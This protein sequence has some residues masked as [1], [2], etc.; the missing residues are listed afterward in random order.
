MVTVEESRQKAQRMLLPPNITPD[1]E[2]GNVQGASCASSD[3]SASLDDEDES[4]SGSEDSCRPARRGSSRRAAGKSSRKRRKRPEWTREEEETLAKVHC[5]VGNQWST[6]AARLPGRT[7]NEVKNIWHSTLR[8]K[9]LKVRSLLRAYAR[10]LR[11]RWD[12]SEARQEAYNAAVEMHSTDGDASAASRD[13]QGT[14]GA[15]TATTAV[16]AAAKPSLLPSQPEGPHSSQGG[17]STKGAPPPPM[18]HPHPSLHQ[19]QQIPTTAAAVITQRMTS[20]SWPSAPSLPA[21]TTAAAAGAATFGGVPAIAVALPST[22]AAAVAAIATDS[23]PAAAGLGSVVTPVSTAVPAA[24]AALHNATA[25]PTEPRPTPPHSSTSPGGPAPAT[26]TRHHPSSP[27]QHQASPSRCMKRS[28]QR[29]HQPHKESPLKRIKAEPGLPVSSH[30]S[31]QQQ[32]QQVLCVD[33][34]ANWFGRMDPSVMMLLQDEGDDEAGGGNTAKCRTEAARPAAAADHGVKPAA[35]VAAA[36]AAPMVLAGR[37]PADS[38]SS[39]LEMLGLEGVDCCYL[40]PPVSGGGSGDGDAALDKAGGSGRSSESEV[41]GGDILDVMRDMG[42]GALAVAVRMGTDGR[43]LSYRQQQQ[44]DHHGYHQQQPSSALA[45]FTPREVAVAPTTMLVSDPMSGAWSCTAGVNNHKNHIRHNSCNSTAG[46]FHHTVRARFSSPTFCDLGPPPATATAHA[47][48]NNGHR[49][50]M[51]D[52]VPPPAAASAG[53]TGRLPSA[54]CNEA[55]HGTSSYL[56]DAVAP[57]QVNIDPQYMQSQQQQQQWWGPQGP[58]QEAQARA[59]HAGALAAGGHMMVPVSPVLPQGVDTP[60]YMDPSSNQPAFAFPSHMPP[61]PAV[62]YPSQ[63][64]PAQHHLMQQHPSQQEQL[65]RTWR[66]PWGYAQQP[67]QQPHPSQSSPQ[68]HPQLLRHQQM[69]QA[70]LPHQQHPQQPQ[71]QQQESQHPYMSQ[72]EPE[73]QQQLLPAVP[74]Q[75]GCR[76]QEQEQHHQEQQLLKQEEQ[77]QQTPQRPHH[78]A[79]EFA[80]SPA[81]LTDVFT[82]GLGALQDPQLLW[83]VA[84]PQTWLACG[85][86]NTV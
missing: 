70:P 66:Y 61:P 42:S 2:H 15:S 36:E 77:V 72:Q 1:A 38:N 6:I 64:P 13:V 74:Y 37:D 86:P 16:A 8:S 39:S 21:G 41:H 68:H 56:S 55:A 29:L 53:P 79:R 9:Q 22:A 28:P 23:G 34:A 24:A 49:Q 57:P 58:Q 73:Q 60:R 35:F 32:P 44:Q 51:F 75:E 48:T 45:T 27:A 40:L 65:Q 10:A 84:E 71:T 59:V 47:A 5:S 20:T 78:E 43:H 14:E 85:P 4:E 80:T 7:A 52:A 18:R 76:Q 17:L 25:I 83:C 81:P 30:Q 67:D 54:V 12:D 63:Y 33:S 11:G 82:M 62:Q 50:G 31:G 19:Q 46:G 26:S 69:L 3:A